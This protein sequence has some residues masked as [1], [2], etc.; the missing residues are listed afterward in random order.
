M[1]DY[2]I[3]HLIYYFLRMKKS[4][5]L[6]PLA[7]ALLAS[8]SSNEEPTVGNT[9]GPVK[10][11]AS[12]NGVANSRAYNQVWEAGDK[13]GIYATTGGKAYTNV[14]YSTGG[15]GDF[16]IVNPGNEIYYQDNNPVTFTAYYPW[17][18]LAEGVTSLTADTWMQANQKK[19]DYLWAQNTG[20]KTNPDVNFKFNHKMTKLVLTIKKGADVSFDEV[21]AA[22]LMLDGFK[23]EGAFD[24]TTGEAKATGNE[25][26]MWEFAGNDEEKCNAPKVENADES[27]TYT[28]ILFPQQF[29]NE[30]PFTATLTDSQS[31]TAKLDFTSANDDTNRNEWVAGRQYNMSVTLHKTSITVNGCTIAPW[32]EKEGENVDAK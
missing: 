6:T 1:P 32:E 25:S 23:H 13:I 11:S 20:S 14:A 9:D 17:A 3:Q 24:I 2:Q 15:T 5:F 29:E 7:L 12:I 21:K 28:L 27:V 22:K 16:A 26:A 30:L 4:L 8:C 19:F 18:D 31:F 10:F